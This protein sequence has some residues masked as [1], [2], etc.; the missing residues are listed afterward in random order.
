MPPSA[1]RAIRTPGTF[2]WRSC[3]IGWFP[4]CRS[5]SSAD[6]VVL[7]SRAPCLLLEAQPAASP[8][9]TIAESAARDKEIVIGVACRTAR[10][11]RR[12]DCPAPFIEHVALRTPNARVPPFL[13]GIA[14]LL[15]NAN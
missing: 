11:E 6:T 4:A 10:G 1:V 8:E 3:S 2:A 5:M 15:T 9:S 13:Y 12:A 7:S 14:E